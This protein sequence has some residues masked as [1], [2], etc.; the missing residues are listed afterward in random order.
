MSETNPLVVVAVTAVGVVGAVL[1]VF[2]SSSPN[3][4]VPSSTA[5]QIRSLG[6]ANRSYQPTPLLKRPAHTPVASQPHVLL[7]T[8]IITPVAS[9][10][11]STSQTVTSVKGG[12]VLEQPSPMAQAVLPYDRNTI[13][14]LVLRMKEDLEK[15]PSMSPFSTRDGELVS[16]LHRMLDK[17]FPVD[18]LESAW[19]EASQTYA[20]IAKDKAAYAAIMD[21]AGQHKAE[22]N[23]PAPTR[24]VDFSTQRTALLQKLYDLTEPSLSWEAVQTQS[25]E[26]DEAYQALV[27]AKNTEANIIE[28][29]QMLRR[30]MG[31]TS[32]PEFKD[33]EDA[34]R[35]QLDGLG[36]SRFDSLEHLQRQWGFL[37][38]AAANISNAK[39]DDGIHIDDP[40]FRM[41][42]YVCRELKAPST[43]TSLQIVN[44]LKLALG[45]G[46]ARAREFSQL[47]T[48]SLQATV[49]NI[50][51]TTRGIQGV[52]KEVAVMETLLTQL[53][54]RMFDGSKTSLNEH[55]QT[56]VLCLK[57]DKLAP[58]LGGSPEDLA[59]GLAELKYP[60]SRRMLSCLLQ[61]EYDRVIESRALEPIDMDKPI[62]VNYWNDHI[63]Y[64]EERRYFKQVCADMHAKNDA[65]WW[66]VFDKDSYDLA[67]IEEK[68]EEADTT[69]YKDVLDALCVYYGPLW[70]KDQTIQLLDRGAVPPEIKGVVPMGQWKLVDYVECIRFLSS[71]TEGMCQAPEPQYHEEAMRT[72]NVI[73][74]MVSMKDDVLHA[75]IEDLLLP[76]ATVPPSPAVRN[77]LG[78]YYA[79]YDGAK[80]ALSKPEAYASLL[81][82]ATFLVR[83][84]SVEAQEPMRKV[85]KFVWEW[86]SVGAYL[87][88]WKF[89]MEYDGLPHAWQK[90][91]VRLSVRVW[92]DK[93]ALNKL[94][95]VTKTETDE[96]QE[97]MTWFGKEVQKYKEKP[98]MVEA[99]V[100]YLTDAT[101]RGQSPLLAEYSDKKGWN[102]FGTTPRQTLAKYM[103][104]VDRPDMTYA[105]EEV[106]M[107]ILDSTT[108]GV[109]LSNA[110]K[111]YWR[112]YFMG[113]DETGNKEG[114]MKAILAWKKTTV[115]DEWMTLV[116]NKDEDTVVAQ[117]EQ[118]EVGGLDVSEHQSPRAL[119]SPP[120]AKPS[121]PL[122][123]S[124]NEGAGVGLETGMGGAQRAEQRIRYQGHVYKVRKDK[125][126]IRAKYIKV[127]GQKVLLK[128]IKGKYRKVN[129]A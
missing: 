93:P 119:P 39:G 67:H 29:A 83:K 19:N 98:Q 32:H 75:V 62:R 2:S 86:V 70:K 123:G 20:A 49:V 68:V 120:P 45:E 92:S 97:V 51:K 125:K 124:V 84:Q 79:Q 44:G 105:K 13:E 65:L 46:D 17:D 1:A 56:M 47:F 43:T 12:P 121:S 40:L 74:E 60:S 100:D 61:R 41:P 113:L 59:R 122:P 52:A 50:I 5:P 95:Y 6:E 8:P 78:K 89:A 91:Y 21:Q 111:V 22:L 80:R 3:G 10:P 63:S 126:D 129:Y 77:A 64:R 9:I 33:R 71:Q 90:R 24:L 28:K 94:N 106:L 72:F 110:Y 87:P 82:A 18:Q 31:N 14:P 127:K 112:N 101:T 108:N 109:P 35:R 96:Y 103:G 81:D 128:E 48:D 99:L 42:V 4:I 118:G 26:V 55:I 116:R 69:V 37:E 115:N 104:V 66:S 23:N 25:K 73:S 117:V 11:I 88:V 76:Y 16:L 107:R 114:M 30:T 38:T 57:L 58:L 85:L 53:N 102:L 34:L 15:N 54:N 27:Q 7:A 36:S